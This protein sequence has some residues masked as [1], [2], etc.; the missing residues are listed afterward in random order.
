MRIIARKRLREFARKHPGA[1]GPLDAWWSEAKH[2]EWS[3]FND[4]RQHY[5]SADQVAGNLVVFN[6]AGNNYRLIVKF[7]YRLKMGF[8]KFIGTHAEYD[9]VD[10]KKL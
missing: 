7:E 1:K 10:V 3:N 2:S 9:K 8:V 6:I 4:I 5:N